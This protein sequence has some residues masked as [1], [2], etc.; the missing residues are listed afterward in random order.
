MSR[1]VVEMME[2][3]SKTW[4]NDPYVLKKTDSGYVATTFSQARTLT[5]QFSAWLLGAGYGKKDSFAI[6]AEGSPEWILG[7]FGL[8]YAG[9]ISVPLSIKLLPEEVPFRLN[10]SGARGILTSHNQLTKVLAAC[11]SVNAKDFLIVYLDDD[12]DWGR[13]QA[14]RQGF[15]KDRI[16]SFND[17]LR[18]GAR[19]LGEPDG[20]IAAK[21]DS[22]A[23]GTAEDDVVTI[24]YTSGTAGNPKGI[25]LTHLN[26]WANCH[27]S[28]L[29]FD[30]PIH[31][32]TLLVL[33]VDHSFA[34]SV[35]LYTA[36]LCGISLYFV[37]SRGGGIA[38]LRNIPQNLKEANPI[39]ILTV[40]AL[41]GNFMKKIIEGIE[42]KGGII[43]KLFKAGI[44][45]G[46]EWHGNGFDRPPFWTRL[47]AFL[48]YRLA[49][50][51]IFR[52]ARRMAF[53]NSIRFCVGGGAL[54]DV[55]QQEFF[56]ALGVPVYQGYGLTEAAP[57][58]SSN[59]PSRHKFGTSGVIAPSVDCRIMDQ[60][61]KELKPGQTGEISISG[62]NVMKC[63]LGNPE[64]TA[65][66]LHDGRLWTGD[67]GYIDSDGFLTVV[68]REKALLVGADG[69]K[70]SPEEIE[71]AVTTSTNLID[72][73]MVWCD[74]KKYSCALITL[75]RNRLEK[76]A[77]SKSIVD[78]HLLLTELQEEFYRF[79][80]D[81]SAKKVQNAWVP[82]VFQIVPQP[83]GEAD[84]TVN[85]TMKIV[86]HK[87]AAKYADL[88]DY[89]YTSE[90]SSTINPR[91]IETLKSMLGLA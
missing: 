59:T 79:R 22:L 82:A 21:L 83:F 91:N 60:D 15:P 27:D 6:L 39:F 53:G 35:G 49:D 26:Y 19:A 28:E 44:R 57:V 81:P 14:V 16:I 51:L 20:T 71:E 52:K 30:H 74:N 36:L 47:K 32:R 23:R 13:E 17:A 61:G 43:E 58:I 89:S 50:L 46:I 66:A 37:D 24:S 63:Y 9:M 8:I 18:E 4:A 69:E 3:A 87:V 45:A 38:T 88:V 40:P 72:Q 42:E 41:S 12:A 75:D 31:F 54:L 7:E 84:G 67:L 62:E 48:P 64:A 10:H 70:Y 56:S 86:R 33:P 55:K 2:Q 11:S 76:F 73:I 5:R 80:K 85:S 1:T 65:E 29:L 25:M 77:R 68:G 78:S 34:H 90:G